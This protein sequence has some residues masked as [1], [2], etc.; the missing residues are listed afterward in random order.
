MSKLKIIKASAG[1]GKTHTLTQEY[2]SLLLPQDDSAPVNAYRHIL[3][4]TFTNKA[5]D[6]M[7]SRVIEELAKLSKREDTYGRRAKAVLTAILHDYTS[8]SVSTIDKFFQGVMRSFAREIGQFASYKVEL[9]TTEVLNQSVDLLMN[10]LEKPENKALL[11]WLMEYSLD[12]IESGGKWD[13]TAEL[14][15]MASLFFREDFKIRKRGLDKVIGDRELIKSL[16]GELDAIIKTYREDLAAVGADGCRIMKDNGVSAGDFK[17]GSRSPFHRFQSWKEGDMKDLNDSFIALQD[18][19]SA[20]YTAKTDPAT[21]NSITSAY[22]CGLNDAVRRAV[23]LLDPN[24]NRSLKYHTAKLMRGNLYLLGIFSDLYRIMDGYLKENNLVLLGETSDVL[25]RIIDGNDTPF[26]YE[27]TGT[28]YD[29]YML[30]EFQDTSHLQWLDFKPLI[31]DSIDQGNSNLIVGDIKQSIYRWRGADLTLLGE[32]LQKEFPA[33]SS[34]LSPLDDNW[35][36]CPEIVGFNNDFYS[37]A[38]ALLEDFDALTSDRVNEYYG[39]SIQHVRH[40]DDGPGH[41]LVKFLPSKQTAEDG[42]EKDWKALALEMIGPTVERLSRSYE[43]SDITFLVRK[44]TEGAQVAAK[45]LELGYDVVTEDSLKISSSAVVRRVVAILKHHISPDDKVN[46]LVLGALLGSGQL[47]EQDFSAMADSSLYGICEALVKEYGGDA[48]SY[49][50]PFILAFLD[51]VLNYMGKFGSNI[52][53]FVEWWDSVGADRSISAPEGRNA[54]RVMTI[55]KAKGLKSEAVVIP[56]LQENLKPSNMLMPYIW[57]KPKVEP[58]SRIGLV[59]LKASSEMA[60]TIFAKE[61]SDEMLMHCVDAVNTAYV[62]MTR[63][64]SEMTIFAPYPDNA[65]KPASSVADMLFRHLKDSLDEDMIYECGTPRPELKQETDAQEQE[66]IRLTDFKV[67]GLGDRLKLSLRGGDFYNRRLGIV[68]HDILSRIESEADI[69]QSVGT[70]V[71][72]GE[73]DASAAAAV[74]GKMRSLLSSVGDRHWF[75]GTCRALREMSIVDAQGRTQRPDRVLVEK[76]KPLGNGRAIV[77]D[78]KFG[79]ERPDYHKQVCEYMKLLREMGYSDIE[80]YIWYCGTNT[81][82]QCEEDF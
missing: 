82:E 22:N 68:N 5:T 13:I 32:E 75:D 77:I 56:F 23:E 57:C 58:F 78:Y 66:G 50:T 12:T 41:V 3:A 64:V 70:A 80:G 16:R 62:A 33:P 39:D 8:F 24:G 59:P 65:S 45:L 73:L 79:A 34:E 72:S 6:E 74:A 37:N 38:G 18:N 46:N 15:S 7:K 27:K 60:R 25:S 76:D 69:E 31:A 14:K 63:A 53:G 30:D 26:I 29:H 36:S 52:G 20:W 61:Y 43:L 11:D 71:S 19:I 28:R 47:P 9:D 42:S 55:H 67:V 81:I 44:N 4:V 40:T 21:K 2:L 1:S 48:T 35:R 17:G 54:I 10:S 51:S 49:D